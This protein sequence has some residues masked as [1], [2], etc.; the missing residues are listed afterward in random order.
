MNNE[1]TPLIN[2]GFGP[3]LTGKETIAELFDGDIAIHLSEK[4]RKKRSIITTI[5]PK[6]M[7]KLRAF[8][9]K[10]TRNTPIYKFKLLTDWLEQEVGDAV[11]KVQVKNKHLT[12]ILQACAQ[13]EEGGLKGVLELGRDNKDRY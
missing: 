6:L 8:K 1:D 3:Q 13:H 12:K 9:T 4:D 5:D 11:V 10:V 2:D 7:E